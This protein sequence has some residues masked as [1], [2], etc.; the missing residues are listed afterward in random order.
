MGIENALAKPKSAIFNSAVIGLINKFYG[1]KSLCIILL[2]WQCKTPS[3]NYFIN[4]LT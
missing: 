3:N 4:D 1:F 2:L